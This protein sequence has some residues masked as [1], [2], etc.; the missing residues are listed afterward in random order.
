M[1]NFNLRL[2]I[3]LSLLL[4]GATDTDVKIMIYNT[5]G[6]VIRTLALGHQSAGSY[7]GRAR[8]AY[9]DGQNALGEP[10]ASGVYFYQLETNTISSMRKMVILK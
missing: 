3:F 9:W 6:V 10:V 5:S 4:C 7:T 2:R 1:C 8:A